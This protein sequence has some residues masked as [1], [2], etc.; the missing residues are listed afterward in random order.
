MK[1]AAVRTHALSLPEASEAPHFNYAAFRVR[2]K[3]FATV[4]PGDEH[5]H[6]FVPEEARE[7]ALA[8]YPEF[9]EKL[10]WGDKVV[11]LRAQLPTAKPAVI[12]ALL[13]Q[14][15][16]NKAPKSLLAK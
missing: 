5:L 1:I 8:M 10:T 14:A 15:W 13:G 16:A 6:L 4:P 3:I 2:G 9:L 12:K 11:G 7:R